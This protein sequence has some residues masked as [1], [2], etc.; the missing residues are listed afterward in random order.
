MLEAYG[1]F[2]VDENG[3]EVGFKPHRW[4]QRMEAIDI[5]KYMEY[6]PGDAWTEKVDNEALLN[7]KFDPKENCSFVP[8]KELYD[9]SKKF[10]KIENSPT[11]KA[12]YDE[13]VNTMHEANEMQ[14]NRLYADDYLLPQETG[15][16]WKRMKR[17][18]AWGKTKV[19]FKYLLESAGINN[20]GNKIRELQLL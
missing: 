6:Q 20:T 11:L 17:H 13:V 16:L 8:K 15:T 3:I 4:L 12:L 9:N 2:L 14:S 7:K 18:S 1:T 10:A 5:D 19:L